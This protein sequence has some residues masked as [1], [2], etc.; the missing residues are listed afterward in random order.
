MSAATLE[1]GDCALRRAAVAAAVVV[2]LGVGS[3]APMAQPPES[4]PKR[5][6]PEQ[7]EHILKL[8]PP[9]VQA[10]E[11]RLL[12]SKGRLEFMERLM[13]EKRPHW[14]KETVLRKIPHAF[15]SSDPA[16]I[17][18]ML[19]GA[20]LSY[21]VQLAIIKLCDEGKGLADLAHY[22]N[23]ADI[24]ERDVLLWAELPNDTKLPLSANEADRET[25]QS[26]DQEQYLRWT[27]RDRK[28]KD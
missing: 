19:E 25:A 9:E 3:I 5:L 10:A 13:A 17:L 21:R 16:H 26:R 14:T 6:S 28:E 27:E 2:S 1:V 18:G 23:A 8:M 20:K 4:R 24:D 22:V 11:R 7:I 15:P 12:E